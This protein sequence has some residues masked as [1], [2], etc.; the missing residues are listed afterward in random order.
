[1]GTTNAA[2]RYGRNSP[3]QTHG[4]PLDYNVK[5]TVLRHG[6]YDYYNGSQVWDTGI[7]DHSIPNSYYLS[8]KA[9]VVWEFNVATD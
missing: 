1:M 5:N 7:P 2:T 6:N 8:G 9:F 3:D 4:E